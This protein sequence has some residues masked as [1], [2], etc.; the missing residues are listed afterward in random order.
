MAKVK[1]LSVTKQ[2]GA[3]GTLAASPAVN[4]GIR[5]VH[6]CQ[7]TRRRTMNANTVDR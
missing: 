2:C 6:E 1:A 3:F 5:E 7:S 4:D